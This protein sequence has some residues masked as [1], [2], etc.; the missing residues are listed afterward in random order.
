MLKPSPEEE[1]SL[2]HT[3]LGWWCIRDTTGL[4]PS[5]TFLDTVV[6]SYAQ[7]GHWEL[8][9]KWVVK[10]KTRKKGPVSSIEDL[11]G[12]LMGADLWLKEEGELWC[13]V[14]V[15]DNSQGEEA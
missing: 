5:L 12:E 8:K 13:L 11:K 7:W 6:F 10:D 2:L 14:G 4:V 3:L 15:S 9:G 1:T